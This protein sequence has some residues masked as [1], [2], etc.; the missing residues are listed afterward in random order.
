MWA[1]GTCVARG[2][3]PAARRNIS[4][5]TAGGRSGP[6]FR[7]VPAA[8]RLRMAAGLGILGRS[9][10]R[11]TVAC[12]VLLI[13]TLSLRAEAAPDSLG[14]G[15]GLQV[16]FPVPV[17]QNGIT[18]TPWVAV[19]YGAVRWGAGRYGTLIL[20]DRAAPYPYLEAGTAMD[21]PVG[22]A[23]YA[24][25][26][27]KLGPQPDTYLLGQR[28][29]LFPTKWL[30]FGVSEIAIADGRFA[31]IPTNWIPFW[32][33]YLTQH[34]AIHSGV[35]GINNDSNQN[36]GID[37][38]ASLRPGITVYGEFFVDDMPQRPENGG[39]YQ[40]GFLVGGTAELGETLRL[41]AEY[42]RVNNYTYTFRVP[43]RSYLNQGRP[44]GFQLGPDADRLIVELRRQFDSTELGLGLE[45]RRHGEGRIGDKWQDI[46]RDEARKR[47]FLYGVIEYTSLI[48]FDFARDFAPG[49]SLE[50]GVAVGQVRNKGN[51]PSGAEGVAEAEFGITWVFTLLE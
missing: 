48:R 14:S 35:E 9:P 12:V 28:L 4:W 39:V 6:S 27:G 41:D 30:R 42:A 2:T 44:L 22:R 45:L 20:D 18:E 38:T 46:G 16:S 49:V 33:F 37:I 7:A 34:I 51:V 3:L 36:L 43:E 1:G 31:G 21:T 50:A 13:L 47:A 29:E 17:L 11:V 25:L 26:V 40:I 24:R 23:E 5:H 10:A 8:V 19:G 15:S 32:P